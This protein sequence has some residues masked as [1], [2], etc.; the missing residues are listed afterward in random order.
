MLLLV[1]F[2]PTYML[3][4]HFWVNFN[5]LFYQAFQVVAKLLR[6]HEKDRKTWHTAA[7]DGHSKFDKLLPVSRN[8]A[9]HL[10]A[11]K[12]KTIVQLYERNH[13]VD[14]QNSPKT[15]VDRQLIGNTKLI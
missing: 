10:Q 7:V 14:L 6:I 12:I 9:K 15:A 11:M 8:E 13:L 4:M 2:G 5:L 3:I 1:A